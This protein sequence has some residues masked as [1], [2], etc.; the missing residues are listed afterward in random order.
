MFEV[1]QCG[2][3]SYLGLLGKTKVGVLGKLREEEGGQSRKSIT[4][5]KEKPCGGGGTPAAVAVIKM[6]DLSS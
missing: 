4:L 1:L 5:G 3:L 2:Q 6:E